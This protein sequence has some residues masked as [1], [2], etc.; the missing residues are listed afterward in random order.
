[1]QDSLPYS[2]TSPVQD[3]LQEAT[4]DP[5]FYLLPRLI[6]DTTAS[7]LHAWDSTRGN[8]TTTD[9][10]NSSTANESAGSESGSNFLLDVKESSVACDC[11]SCF[12]VS[13]GSQTATSSTDSDATTSY[14]SHNY[15]SGSDTSHNYTSGS[16][17]TSYSSLHYTTGSD[18]S[19]VDL[20]ARKKPRT[21]SPYSI[22]SVRAGGVIAWGNNIEN[23]EVLL[24]N[25]NDADGEDS[26][27]ESV[28]SG[29]KKKRVQ[30]YCYTTHTVRT[31]VL[32]PCE[33]EI[34]KDRADKS[35][36]GGE[37]LCRTP[38]PHRNGYS[39]ESADYSNYDREE[40]DFHFRRQRSLARIRRS[41]LS[42]ARDIGHTIFPDSTDTSAYDFF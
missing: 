30:E 22:S 19:S 23:S 5:D 16:D 7:N 9:G 11:S 24:V 4:T 38:S 37:A 3:L 6:P 1:M 28:E 18:N 33:S 27:E 39:Y 15:T 12:H 36:I 35:D 42:A 20:P 13:Y 31:E 34:S 2:P 41:Q 40:V 26:A 32:D 8:E 17:V 29:Y 21:I 10:S 14:T 25:P